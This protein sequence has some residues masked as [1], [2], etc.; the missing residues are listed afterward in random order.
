MAKGITSAYAPMG[1]V[2]VSDKI[3]EPLYEDG[4]MLLHG[5]TYGGHPV[6]AAMALVNIEIFEREGVLENVRANE[7]YLAPEAAR[8]P[9]ARADRR[10]RARRRVLLGARA[11]ARRGGH[12]ASAPKSA[13]GCCAASSPAGCSRRA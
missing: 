9:G 10:R 11:G 12:A 1:A 13:S 2:A 8:G 4:R 6:A 3:A 7:A 5:I